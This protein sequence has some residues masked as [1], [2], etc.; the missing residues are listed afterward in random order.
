MMQTR[1]RLTALLAVI[2]LS[3]GP[4]LA[5]GENGHQSFDDS[6]VITQT[7]PSAVASLAPSETIEPIAGAGVAAAT[8]ETRSITMASMLKNIHPATVH[9]PIAL[10]LMA[11]LLEAL[12]ALGLVRNTERAIELALYGTAITAAIAATFGWIH[13]GFWLG[14]D[15]AMH[16]HR[17]TGTALVPVAILLAWIAWRTR[18]DDRCRLALRAGL[19]IGSLLILAQGYWGS[20][21]AHGIDHLT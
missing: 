1:N 3:A 20:E 21:L 12:G 2:I 4:A 9:F 10:L 14:G 6:S 5:H 13:T 16:W 17:W 8:G 15:S 11:A 19:G 18:A 7:G